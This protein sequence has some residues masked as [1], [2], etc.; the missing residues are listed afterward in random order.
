[1]KPSYNK[2]ASLRKQGRR[3]AAPDKAPF[4]FVCQTKC[5]DLQGRSQPTPQSGVIRRY[6]TNFVWKTKFVGTCGTEHEIPHWFRLPNEFRWAN[7]IRPFTTHFL[8]DRIQKRKQ[9]NLHDISCRSRKKFGTPSLFSQRDHYK[10]YNTTII[11]PINTTIIMSFSTKCS[12]LMLL[13]RTPWLGPLTVSW[14]MWPPPL[15]MTPLLPLT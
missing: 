3:K 15:L 4:N 6:L 9:E 12:Y 5:V 10:H 8:E 1:M 2:E 7:E 14:L 13:L 11:T